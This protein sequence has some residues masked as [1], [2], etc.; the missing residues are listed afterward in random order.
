MPWPTVG[1]NGSGPRDTDLRATPA[2][3]TLRGG[4]LA[5]VVLAAGSLAHVSARGE[6]PGWASLLSLYVVLLAAC[7]AVLGREASARLLVAVTVGGQL[8][9][10]GA[11]SALAG[12]HPADSA[13]TLV[14]DHHG[15]PTHVAADPGVLPGWLTHGV[16]D[17]AAEPLM[18]LLHL[19]AA[20]GVGLWLAVGERALWT[21]LALARCRARGV[22]SYALAALGLHPL[23]LRS[24]PRTARVVAVE[25][26]PMPQLPVWSRGPARRGPPTVVLPH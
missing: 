5:T 15:T 1:S 23:V 8:V 12:H 6:M 4:L 14:H 3:R 2:L 10:H 20:A 26:A 7:A 21:L 22:L 18:A 13:T 16:Q 19:V 25:V 24:Q 9:V 11:L 17:M